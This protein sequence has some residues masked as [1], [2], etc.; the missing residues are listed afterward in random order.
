M[1]QTL[2]RGPHASRGEF[3]CGPRTLCVPDIS[4]NHKYNVLA[5][6]L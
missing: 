3:S 4:L 2:A 6:Q 5:T 1:V